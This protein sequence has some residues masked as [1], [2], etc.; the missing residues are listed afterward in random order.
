MDI[1]NEIE[2]NEYENSNGD[3]DLKILLNDTIPPMQ[4]KRQYM[5]K[6]RVY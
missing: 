6:R 5:K 4:I 1:K 3:N 2:K